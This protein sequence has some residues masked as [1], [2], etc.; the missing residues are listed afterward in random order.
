MCYLICGKLKHLPTNPEYT[1]AFRRPNDWIP[2]RSRESHITVTFSRCVATLFVV[3]SLPHQSQWMRVP[4]NKLI[5]AL[6]TAAVLFATS[7]QALRPPN[8][9]A[10]AADTAQ[11]RE[12]YFLIRRTAPYG[13]KI[14]AAAARLKAYQHFR[15]GV[16][17]E[18]TNRVFQ[19][20]LASQWHTEVWQ[21]IGPAPI[22]DG[23]TPQNSTAAS[24]SAVSGRVN[25]IA[26]DPVDN[27]VY[28]GGA[29]GG[30]WRTLNH[31]VSWTPLTDY[32]GS[33]AVGAIAI[34][35][36]PHP[37]NQGTIY[38]GTGEG[39]FSG[40]SYAG[41]GVYKSTDSGKTWQGPFGSAQFAGRSVD[42]IAVD[43]TDP[44][45]VLAGTTFGIAGIEGDVP[46]GAPARGIYRSS[47]GGH[48]W[49]QVLPNPSATLRIS[50]I[51]Q[52]P[53]PS[54][55][56]AGST[57][58]WAAA[59]PVSTTDGALWRSDDAGQT[60]TRVDGV[61]AGLPAIGTAS[62]LIRTWITATYAGANTILYYGTSQAS[63]TLYRS[64]DGGSTWSVLTAANGYCQGQCTYDMPVYVEP[65]TSTNVYTGGAGTGDSLPSSFMLSTDG[66]TSFTDEMRGV[67][68]NSALHAD[69]HDI[70]T[71]PG[72][73]AEVWVANDGGV[74]YSMDRG[75]HW[76]SANT[77][78]SL[79]QFQGCDLHPTDPN[80]AYGGTQDNGTEGYLG[81]STAW[82]HSDD[83]DGGFALID[84]AS[85]NFVTH[86]YYNVSNSQILAA[87]ALNGPAST[88]NDY[89]Y[90]AGEIPGYLSSGMNAADAVLFYAPMHLDRGN[91]STL[92]FGTQ[93]LYIAPDYFNQTVTQENALTGNPPYT[94]H[95]F[96]QL[97]SSTDFG[98]PISP[99]LNTGVISA[100]ATVPNV[101]PNMNASTIFIG[102]SNG[103]VWRSTNSGA[104]FTDVDP[105]IAQYVSQI[106]VYPRDPSIVFEARAGFTGGLPAHNV[107]KSTDG[108]QTWSDA[109]N[110]LPDI[111][112]NTLVWDPVFPGQI[113]AGTD[114]GMYLSSDEGATWYP[115]N[116]GMPNVAVFSLAA[117]R[118]THTV[119]ACTHGRGAFRLNLDAIFI[120]GFDG[121]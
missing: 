109:S 92:Y 26:I 71:W 6:T 7:A 11:R 28:I 46:P 69:M 42:A 22:I 120:D 107:R 80:Q 63:G 76:V 39:N 5:V 98:A 21:N 8:V 66:G 53:N 43:S 38:L 115:Y 35:P 77:N 73:P 41:I 37:L 3:I 116:N 90:Y 48:T 64:V 119:L 59:S 74:F 67:D 29:Q 108:G 52:D 55:Q 87:I 70:T 88:P 15:A 78:L 57:R 93:S 62:A 84:Q 105:S 96:T 114:V 25:A 44:Q 36:G 65:G 1:H 30:V 94:V 32:L 61:A 91:P 111:P 40:D 31:G 56:T 4:V 106:A 97:A 86:T 110:G 50:R 95:I 68:G 23:Q 75:A 14:D 10:E 113:W 33:L 18:K 121:N 85:P 34:A 49:T 58:F 100:I 27:A 72:N 118:N 17:A 79:T 16:T 82:S 102:T 60:W 45:I 9:D 19:T 103:N 12:N 13:V 112:V 24:R 101:V 89:A 51:V 81:G 54:L 20:T 117:N 47:D 104:T 83:G 99:S 2:H